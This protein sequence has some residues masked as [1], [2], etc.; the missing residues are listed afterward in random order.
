MVDYKEGKFAENHVFQISDVDIFFLPRTGY[1]GITIF[2]YQHQNIMMVLLSD[3]M[4]KMGYVQN[5]YSE[6][7]VVPENQTLTTRPQR[8]SIWRS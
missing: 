6:N 5:H 7:L 8:Q 1:C 2:M 3:F 4:A